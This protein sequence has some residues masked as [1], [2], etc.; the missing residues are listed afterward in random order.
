MHIAYIGGNYIALP[1]QLH[2]RWHF[3]LKLIFGKKKI[4]EKATLLQLGNTE[5]TVIFILISR[6]K[7]VV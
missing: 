2:F 3:F 1:Q 5:S 6:N 7:N 4:R